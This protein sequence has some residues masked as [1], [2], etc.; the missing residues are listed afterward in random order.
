MEA[1]VWMTG[2]VGTEVEY[3]PINAR[4]AFASFRLACTP[5]VNRAGEW[6]DAATTWISVSC[7]RGL[8]E[9]VKCSLSKGDPVVVV[10]RLRTHQWA[11]SDGVLH[12]QLRLEATSVGHDLARGTSVFHRVGRGGPGGG[13]GAVPE[14][15]GAASTGEGL[16]PAEGLGPEVDLE[17]PEDLDEDAPD[18]DESKPAA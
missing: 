1:Q 16:E 3:R 9:H 14:E 4:L 8:A 12:E 15:T 11:D 7:S 18:S 10:G 6:G 13:E 5:R 2:R 17:P